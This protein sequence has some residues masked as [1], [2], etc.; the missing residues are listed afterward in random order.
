MDSGEWIKKAII[1]IDSLTLVRGKLSP[2]VFGMVM[3]WAAE[4]QA[5]LM[6]NWYLAR[7]HEPLQKIDPLE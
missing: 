7:Q 1:A 3:E 5:E 2:R 4:N 6:E